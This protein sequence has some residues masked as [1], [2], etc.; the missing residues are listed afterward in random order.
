MANDFDIGNLIGSTITEATAKVKNADFWEVIDNTLKKG[1]GKLVGGFVSIMNVFG[2][3]DMSKLD[4]T[5]IFEP[6]LNVLSVFP[7]GVKAFIRTMRVVEI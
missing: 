2:D 6:L 3:I 7:E 4:F 5:H 1:I